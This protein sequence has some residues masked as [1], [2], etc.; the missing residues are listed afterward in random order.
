V[1][2]NVR[3]LATSFGILLILS[4]LGCNRNR[5]Q[6]GLATSMTPVEQ[7]IEAAKA[8]NLESVKAYI[9]DGVD[10]N[11]KD[12]YEQSALLAAVSNNRDDV[13]E[14][15]LANNAN[16]NIVDMHGQSP[17]F[18]A[19][20][21]RNLKSLELL[22][23]RKADVNLV[24]NAGETALLRAVIWSNRKIVSALM[25]AGADPGRVSDEVLRSAGFK[26]RDEWNKQVQSLIE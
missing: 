12:K 5:E 19:S 16:P 20:Y 21:E 1:K 3:F 2:G 11:A 15:L 17:A 23:A 18:W 4:I 26:S 14:F 10:P 13:T 8:G 9:A 25:K 7:L 6:Q 24:T 22:I